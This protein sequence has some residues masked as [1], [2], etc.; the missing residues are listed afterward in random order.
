MFQGCFAGYGTADVTEVFEVNESMNVIVAGVSGWLA[1]SMCRYPANQIVGH[2]N[3]EV[4]RAT[5]EN[6]G[7]EVIFAIWHVGMVSGM[8]VD[9]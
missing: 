4:S 8:R 9:G 1:L 5:G 6:V 7:P 3:V 2:T